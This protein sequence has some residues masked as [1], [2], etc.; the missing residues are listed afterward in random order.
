MSIVMKSVRFFFL[1]SWAALTVLPAQTVTMVSNLG[2]SANGTQSFGSTFDTNMSVAVS[3]VTDDTPGSLF[4]VSV[5][6]GGAY[7]P[8]GGLGACEVSVYSDLGGQPGSKLTTLSGIGFP[9]NQAA[10]TFT[11]TSLLVLSSNAT[12]WI[13]ASS[14]SSVSNAVYLGVLTP[15]HNADAGALWA[16]GSGKYKIGNGPWS[17][18]ASLLQFKVTATPLPLPL[19]ISMN[20]AGGPRP[21]VLMYQTN[22]FRFDLKQNSDLRTTNWVNAVGIS[23]ASSNKTTIISAPL[24]S[25][26]MFYHLEL[27]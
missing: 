15:S 12:Y 27:H 25:Q 26:K 6:L 13:V 8:F 7:R 20:P 19:S 10:Y 1:F 3:F 24:S 18:N 17:P 5:S 2:Q 11:N 14:P 9:T 22:D 23:T 21:I 4:T 16:V